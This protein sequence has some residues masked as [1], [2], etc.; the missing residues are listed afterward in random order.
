VQIDGWTLAWQALNL[1][2]LLVLLRWLFYRPVLA[3][4]QKRRDALDAQ[5]RQAEEARRSAEA[6]QHTL[7][8]QRQA[9]ASERESLLD[10]AR[11]DADHWQAQAREA[12][13][14][15]REDRLQAARRQL[16]EERDT[17]AAALQAQAARLALA[18]A[19]QCLATLPGTVAADV[20]QAQALIRSLATQAPAERE[21]LAAPDPV[22]QFTVATAHELTGAQRAA[23]LAQAGEALGTEA[24]LRFETD[25]ALLGGAELRWPHARLSRHWAAALAAQQARLSAGPATPA[26]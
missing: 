1:G 4:V 12:A 20:E 26:A 24:R 25:A 21:R 3:V 9:L 19:R 14:R 16:A 7:A 13:A 17:A 5:A 11:K 8:D 6:L 2:L 18:M 22:G 15:E 23:L 10:A